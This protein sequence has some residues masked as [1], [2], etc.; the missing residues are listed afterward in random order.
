MEKSNHKNN[1]IL[2]CYEGSD[3]LLDREMSENK[4]Q[5]VATLDRGNVGNGVLCRIIYEEE[6]GNNYPNEVKRKTARMRINNHT[7]EKWTLKQQNGDFKTVRKGLGAENSSV[8]ELKKKSLIVVDKPKS[9]LKKTDFGND[10]IKGKM[11]SP[12]SSRVDRVRKNRS[13]DVDG[14]ESTNPKC[15]RLGEENTGIDVT[16]GSFLDNVR[17]EGEQ[18]FYNFGEHNRIYYEAGNQQA[19]ATHIEAERLKTIK[20]PLAL[21][22][23]PSMPVPKL[24]PPPRAP[25][26]SLKKTTSRDAKN[27]LSSN[28]KTQEK[29]KDKNKELIK[30]YRRELLGYL[31]KPYDQAEYDNLWDN[32]SARTPVLIHKESRRGGFDSQGHM[33]QS[34]FDRYKDLKL[35][36]DKVKFNRGKVLNLLRMFVFYLQKIPSL[37][38]GFSKPW[39]VDL[40]K[41]ILPGS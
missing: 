31:R 34:Y 28:S 38:N 1:T 37:P 6:E 17:V 10:E 4:R 26:S 33:G 22:S 40:F 13:I 32:M 21:N 12:V 2:G 23:T 39:T 25:I 27:M 11:T 5:R 16:F 3:F 35:E 24:P 15:R 36:I 8:D 30:K 29:K 20:R 9:H 41:T 19:K 14:D 18:V 7:R